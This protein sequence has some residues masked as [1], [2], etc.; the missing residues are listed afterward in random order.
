MMLCQ[1]ARRTVES[2]RAV[3]ARSSKPT[4]SEHTMTVL[5]DLLWRLL[6][7]A[8]TKYLD[9]VSAPDELVVH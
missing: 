7:V 4:S 1:P 8:A 3:Q 6:D 5:L 9:L 2:E